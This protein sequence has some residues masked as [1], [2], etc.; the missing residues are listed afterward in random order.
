[1]TLIPGC[2]ISYF[3]SYTDLLSAITAFFLFFLMI[4]VLGRVTACFCTAGSACTVYRGLIPYLLQTGAIL[5]LETALKMMNN[6][7]IPSTSFHSPHLAQ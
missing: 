4:T 5:S 3:W 6:I 1:M 7:P 2:L